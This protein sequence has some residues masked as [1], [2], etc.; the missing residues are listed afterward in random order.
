MDYFRNIPKNTNGYGLTDIIIGLSGS[1]SESSNVI[2]HFHHLRSSEKYLL[3][4]ND[5]G[6]I[7]GDEVDFIISYQ[8]NHIMEIQSGGGIFIP[9]KIFNAKI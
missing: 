3:P 1:L 7:N 4:V 6:E 9:G 5:H 8:L 2:L